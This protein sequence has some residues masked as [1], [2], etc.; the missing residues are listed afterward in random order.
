MSAIVIYR[1]RLGGLR[2]TLPV[3]RASERP[4]GHILKAGRDRRNVVTAVS[5]FKPLA[6]KCFEV[7]A[8]EP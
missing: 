2:P 7:G 8:L 6:P 3:E 4:V 1:K 5:R